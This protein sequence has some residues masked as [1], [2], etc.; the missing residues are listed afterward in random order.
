MASSIAGGLGAFGSSVGWKFETDGAE[1]GERS[2]FQPIVHYALGVSHYYDADTHRF[3][4]Q[5]Y[6]TML[7]S[8]NTTILS[9]SWMETLPDANHTG[10]VL[11]NLNMTN[12]RF[13]T[14]LDN[15]VIR[16][17]LGAT[18]SMGHIVE[19][20]D[21]FKRFGSLTNPLNL[22]KRDGVAAPDW[23]SFN[24]YGE[25]MKEG[26]QFLGDFNNVQNTIREGQNLGT[27]ANWVQASSGEYQSK[28]CCAASPSGNGPGQ[29]SIIVGEVYM[30]DFGGIDGECD[31]G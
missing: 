14:L 5:T 30:N 31:S 9:V 20:F 2:T 1:V 12:G 25:N 7:D 28:F 4:N 23:L 22:K 29:N 24:T 10:G 13:V 19:E 16:T 27:V 21:R 15:G 26:A 17:A 11:E 3:L 8:Y 18:A 6:G